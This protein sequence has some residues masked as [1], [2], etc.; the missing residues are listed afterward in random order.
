[1]LGFRIGIG[2]IPF[3][4]RP[5]TAFFYVQYRN[6]TRIW[7]CNNLLFGIHPPPQDHIS[8]GLPVI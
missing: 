7:G 5:A 2:S 6:I 1:M 3:S 8:E 4:C